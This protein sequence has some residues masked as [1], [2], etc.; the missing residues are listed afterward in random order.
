[1]AIQLGSVSKHGLRKAFAL[2]CARY[3]LAL[4]LWLSHTELLCNEAVF[5]HLINVF[6]LGKGSLVVEV[7][8]AHLLADVWLVY[9]LWMVPNEAMID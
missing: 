7:H 1:M 6:F 4:G 9:T 3:T 8:I 2:R 5:D